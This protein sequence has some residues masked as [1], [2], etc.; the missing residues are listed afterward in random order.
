MTEKSI[1]ETLN[2][3]SGLSHLFIDLGGDMSQFLNRRSVWFRSYVRALPA[4]RAFP[5]RDIIQP[6]ENYFLDMA[7]LAHELELKLIEHAQRHKT[8]LPVSAAGA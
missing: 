5:A 7:A 1:V 3:L 2:I 4:T 6:T 8:P